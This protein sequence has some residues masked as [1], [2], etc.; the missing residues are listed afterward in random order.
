MGVV[1]KEKMDKNKE[2]WR[3]SIGSEERIGNWGR[4]SRSRRETVEEA[5]IGRSRW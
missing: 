3:I 4:R 5:E 2:N 1:Q